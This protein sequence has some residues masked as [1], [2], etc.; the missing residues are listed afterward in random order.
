LKEWQI[1]YREKSVSAAQAVKAVKSGDRVVLAH[2]CGEPASL[3][4]ALV[5]RAGELTDVEILHLVA[6]GPAKYA[7]PGMEPHFRH[8][9][10]F[11]GGSTRKAVEEKRADFTPCFLHEVPR[12]FKDNL[13]PV[14]AALIQLAPAKEELWRK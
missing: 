7:Q 5:D 10:L 12:L 8:N 11:V 13:L 1:I 6:M 14:D 4:N 9:S 3:V 2:A